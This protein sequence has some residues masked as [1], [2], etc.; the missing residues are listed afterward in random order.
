MHLPPE[1]Q[2]AFISY[3]R[4]DSE[5]AL[6][7]AGDLKAAGAAVW[8][9]QLDI[10]PG[11]RWARAVQDAL[12]VCPRILVILSPASV[13][14]K[15]VEDE[16]AFA[17]EEQKSV[18][19]ILYRECQVP[20]RLRS[21]QR[22]DCTGSYARALE[23]LSRALT[24]KCTSPPRTFQTPKRA[25]QQRESFDF[26]FGAGLREKLENSKNAV[27]YFIVCAIVIVPLVWLAAYLWDKIYGP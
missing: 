2:T 3:S 19:P 20:V 25:Y 27:L 23:E 10:A 14:S 18:I 15:N 26:D 9:D 12:N 1:P 5:F 22:V 17:L 24:P 4:E 6:R 8:L 16:I 13:G 11:E 21:L 7:L